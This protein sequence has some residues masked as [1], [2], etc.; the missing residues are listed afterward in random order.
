[1]HYAY[2]LQ[3]GRIYALCY[4]T[5]D[6]GYCC[7]TGVAWIA[8]LLEK[9]RPALTT[10][11]VTITECSG[12]ASSSSYT[13]TYYLERAWGDRYKAII[14]QATDLEQGAKAAFPLIKMALD[15]AVCYARV[16]HSRATTANSTYSSLNMAQFVPQTTP[17]WNRLEYEALAADILFKNVSVPDDIKAECASTAV[18]SLSAYDGNLI[19]F[20][21]DLPEFG[22]SLKAILDLG[23]NYSSPKAWASAWLS[24]RFGDRLTI[25]DSRELL[26]SMLERLKGG[27]YQLGRARRS[28]ERGLLKYEYCQTLIAY[29]KSYS[30][31]MTAVKSL[32]DWDAWPTLENT[33]DMI[34]LSFVVDWFV[35]VG[36]LLNQIDL[37]VKTP[38]IRA[39]S[40]YA[41]LKATYDA[42]VYSREMLIT[43]HS[44]H[45]YRGPAQVLSY[46][47]PFR[48]LE[49]LPSFSVVNCGDAASLLVQNML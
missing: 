10:P 46:I 28:W 34:P 27:S 40:Q 14:R 45:Y 37:A 13:E 24:G 12:D 49:F 9:S 30:G 36:D 44:V 16:M 11:T 26:G 32:M 35:S 3:Y 20:A 23:R 48:D 41:S 15:A 39:A 33:W 8:P 43:Q 29:N 38:Y 42:Q 17:S 5:I 4:F 22:G 25:S 2:S 6:T 7:R 21:K 1:M 18:E 31:L 19:A 47:K